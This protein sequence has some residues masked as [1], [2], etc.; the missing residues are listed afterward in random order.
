VDH[1]QHCGA[2]FLSVVIGIRWIPNNCVGIIEKRFS[3]KVSVRE[4]QIM[5]LNGE[6]GYQIDLLR[7]GVHLFYWPIQYRIHRVPLVT[8]SQGKIGYVY[9]RDGKP[10]LPGQTLGH[11]VECNNFQDARKFLGNGANDASTGQRGR[12][13][14]IIREGVYAI[15]L[16]LFVVV[17]QDSVYRLDMQGRQELATLVGWQKELNDIRG[18]DPV[19][20]GEEVTAEDPLVPGK[21]I[22]VD[23]L[24][25]VTI[26]D[27]RLTASK[28]AGYTGEGKS[29]IFP[30]GIDRMIVGDGDHGVGR[31]KSAV[32]LVDM[33]CGENFRR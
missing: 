25:I 21:Q 14:A 19:V 5:A 16:G 32:D 13:R 8:I 23:S 33:D 24:G 9:A 4:G 11:V 20:I 15:N 29:L 17:T 18:F 7:G 28:L 22:V 27:G 1:R 30:D 6:A 2:D 3:R 10:L 26:Q 12:Q 31:G